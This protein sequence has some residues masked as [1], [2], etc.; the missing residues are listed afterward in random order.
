MTILPGS[1]AA[2]L[3]SFPCIWPAF[4]HRMR[5]QRAPPSVLDA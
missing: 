3:T 4:N 2:M 5:D 1:Q